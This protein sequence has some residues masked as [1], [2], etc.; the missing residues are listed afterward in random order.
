MSFSVNQIRM[1]NAAKSGLTTLLREKLGD[2]LITPALNNLIIEQCVVSGGAIASILTL[3]QVN[4]IDLYFKTKEGL[5]L[6]DE[7]MAIKRN[8]NVIK[9]A[10]SHYSSA[11]LNG[12]VITANATTLFN[13]LQVITLSTFAEQ[14]EVFDFIHCRPYYDIKE[15]KLYI[16]VAEYNSII[17]KQLIANKNNV[18]GIKRVTKFRSR[19]WNYQEESSEYVS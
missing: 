6:F 1:I 14:Q 15:D 17:N 4:D 9:D 13:D 8:Q 12:K 2:P 7:Y 18:P 3:S 5:K 19:G 16:S 10:G 11:K